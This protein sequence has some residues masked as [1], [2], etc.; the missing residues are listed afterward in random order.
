MRW[1]GQDA[2]RD[3][4]S[5]DD[6]GMRSRSVGVLLPYSMIMTTVLPLAERTAKQRARGWIGRTACR[7]LEIELG[8][9]QVSSHLLGLDRL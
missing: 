8:S 4:K 6:H 1:S 3:A 9:R 5:V 2:G 7:R